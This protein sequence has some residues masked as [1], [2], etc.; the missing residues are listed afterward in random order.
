MNKKI[1]KIKPKFSFKRLYLNILFF[2]VGRAFQSLSGVDKN[3][4]KEVKDLPEDFTFCIRVNPFGPLIVIKKLKNNKL[5]FL[6]IKN[7]NYEDINLIIS[8]KNIE[9][10]FSVFTFR[11]SAFLSYAQNG[12]IVKGNL[13][14]T[15]SI[16][17]ILSILEAYL[18]P[19]FIVKPVLKRYPKWNFF[20]K[21]K[22]RILI[23]LKI[24][25]GI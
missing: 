13:T 7:L 1:D 16:M 20:Y 2:F 11:I 22:N 24:L 19:K 8:F 9:R 4:K 25:I 14:E 3:V 21:I 18:L 6:N 15:M 10:A 12:F 23:Y 5:K 17:R